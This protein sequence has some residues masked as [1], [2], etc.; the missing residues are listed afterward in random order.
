MFHGRRDM[1][2]LVNALGPKLGAKIYE[3]S[4]IPAMLHGYL[5]GD[6]APISLV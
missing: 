1:L 3:T 4:Q 2:T 6:R 5:I